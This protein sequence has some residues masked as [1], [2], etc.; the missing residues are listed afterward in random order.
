MTPIQNL[1][2]VAMILAGGALLLGWRQLFGA[3]VGA[4]CRSTI[5]CKGTLECAWGY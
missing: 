2:L 4:A 3:G 1:V 5:G